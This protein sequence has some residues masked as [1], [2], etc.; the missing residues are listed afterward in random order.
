M[1]AVLVASG[2]PARSCGIG[3][4][5]SS[6]ASSLGVSGSGG[7]GGGLVSLSLDLRS[8]VAKLREAKRAA[9]GEGHGH[10]G[11]AIRAAWH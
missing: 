9:G 3:G 8:D 2:S 1:G 5:L 10:G 11:R 6:P 7:L 4:F